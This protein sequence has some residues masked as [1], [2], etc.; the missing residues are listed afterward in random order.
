MSGKL[1]VGGLAWAAQEGDLEQEFG[2]FG[3]IREVK[4]ILDRET[5]RS[6]G[7]AF[8]TFERP[9]DAQKALSAMDGANIMGRQVRVSVAEDRKGGPPRRDDRA[10]RDDVPTRNSDRDRDDRGGEQPGRRSR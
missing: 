1:F 7:F 6:R 4:V 8:V 2:S 9:E 5:G 3:K 10:P